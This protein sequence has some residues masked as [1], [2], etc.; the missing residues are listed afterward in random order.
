MSDNI[1]D[2]VTSVA[3][4]NNVDALQSFHNEINAKIAAAIDDKRIEVAQR[5]IQRHQQPQEEK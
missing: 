2:F 4:G 5:M 3:A 1:K